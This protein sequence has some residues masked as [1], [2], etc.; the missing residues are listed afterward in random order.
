MRNNDVFLIFMTSVTLAGC[1]S[2]S[3]DPT[4]P[5][6]QES[7]RS[8]PVNLPPP[9]AYTIRATDVLGIQVFGEPD[10]TLDKVR[11]DD[12]GFIQYPFLGQVKAEGM[13][14]DELR[15]V[16]AKGLARNYLV[17]PQVTVSVQ[18]AAQQLVSVEGEVEKPGVYEIDRNATLLSAIARAES[19]TN[20]A[21]LDEI[22]VFRNQGDQRLAA[23]FNLKEIRGGKAPDPRLM[24]GD[25]IVVGSSG[26]K[27]LWQDVLRAAPIFN[28]FVVLG[29]N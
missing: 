8:F 1:T 21:K 12:A 28:A 16:L 18:E 20:V 22:V 23:R 3:I 27:S 15:G 29:R 19:T 14:P 13:T 17:N 11:V 5:Q 9:T 10:L 2:T 4:L 25:T 7:Y 24:N 26:A 6:G